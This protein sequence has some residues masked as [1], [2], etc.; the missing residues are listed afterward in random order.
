MERRNHKFYKQIKIKDFFAK[1][2]MTAFLKSDL[3]DL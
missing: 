1:D 3:K 2:A